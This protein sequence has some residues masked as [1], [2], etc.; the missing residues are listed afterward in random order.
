MKFILETSGHIYNDKDKKRLESIGFKFDKIKKTEYVFDNKIWYMDDFDY[1]NS[2][3]INTLEELLAF[4]KKWG[5]LIIRKYRKDKN[6]LH[7]EIYDNYR[8]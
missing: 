7:L 2:I 4:R 5:D 1:R 6:I 8:E 3:E